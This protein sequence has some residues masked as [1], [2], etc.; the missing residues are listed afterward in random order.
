MTVL[1]DISVLA[2][3]LRLDTTLVY[4]EILWALGE[5]RINRVTPPSTQYTAWKRNTDGL[6]KFWAFANER[7]GC[8][9]SQDEVHDIW[10]CID[11]TLRTRQ[12]RPFSFQDYLMIAV[13]SDQCCAI[14]FALRP[15]RPLTSSPGRHGRRRVRAD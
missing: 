7:L 8:E 6:I 5:E 12:R 3:Q 10:K 14:C 13:H 15:R 4:K 11:L 2:A 9:L 1:E